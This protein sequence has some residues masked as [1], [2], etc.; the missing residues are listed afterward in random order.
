MANIDSDAIRQAYED[1][2]N[3]S[4]PTVWAVFKYEDK[5]IV[6]TGD[7]GENYDDFLNFCEDD[8]RIYAYVRVETGDEMSKRAKFALITWLGKGVSAM[9]KAK[10]STDKALL[11]EACPNFALELLEEDKAEISKEKVVEAVKKAGGANYGT[12]N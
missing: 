12:G 2:R 9:N 3:D 11:K 4:S 1:V 7:C 5:K 6:Y 10:V 8:N